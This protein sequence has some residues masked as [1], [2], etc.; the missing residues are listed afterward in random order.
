V[1]KKYINPATMQLVAVGDV[2]KIKN[3]LEK[4]GLVEMVDLQ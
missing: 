4:Y 2:S 1:A 3:V